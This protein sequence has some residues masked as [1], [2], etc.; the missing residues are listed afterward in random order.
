MNMRFRIFRRDRHDRTY[1]SLTVAFLRR[2]PYVLALRAALVLS[3]ATGLAYLLD[4]LGLSESNVVMVFVLGVLAVT[5]LAGRTLG[6]ISSV[7]GVLAFN[8]LFT[9]PKFTLV[10]ND[11]TYLITFAVMLV[12][13]FTTSGL[14]GRIQQQAEAVAQR[15][16]RTE[17]L[18]QM[19]RSLLRHSGRTEVLKNA[20]QQLRH[21]LSTEVCCYQLDAD[22]VLAA[23]MLTD[24]AG[25]EAR[26]FSKP[27]EIQL[28]E[29][30]ARNRRTTVS[31][32]PNTVNTNVLYVPLVGSAAV[33]GVLGVLFKGADRYLAQ[34]LTGLF[35]TFA[36][37][38][39]LAMD[40]EQLAEEHERTRLDA[41]G[42][43]LKSNLL[44]SISHD[45]RTPLSGISGSANALMGTDHEPGYETRREL[46]HSIYQESTW[47]SRVVENLLSLTR[48]EGRE[49]QPSRKEEVVD[50][51]V[52]STVE[53]CKMRLENRT[54]KTSLPNKVV[55]APMDGN[56][57]EQVLVNLVD[58]AIKHT[59]E[60]TAINLEVDCQDDGL[61]FMVTD[62]GP[63]FDTRLIPHLF[64]R[65]TAGLGEAD[66]RRGVG[67]GLAICKTI[68]DAHGG[69][70]RADNAPS[71]GARMRVTIPMGRT[72]V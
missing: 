11:S 58:N 17:A 39:S 72:D 27:S 22:D 2:S 24:S 46:A 56:L 21:L 25:E 30:V 6:I 70:I 12:V 60:G 34:E 71:G 48:L 9:A 14:T 50:D 8:F 64:D 35:E 13:T 42:E 43:R 36:A 18:Y 40:R 10:V 19:S 45:L 65:F 62:D 44:R 57:M 66:S 15:E 69:S 1:N 51:L 3:T 49:I 5:V 20:L 26:V 23:P 63:G 52:A 68:V 47:L 33:H 53:H 4:Q 59:P 67:L 41:E 28:A 29:W 54:L 16:R 55:T 61:V 38:I 7:I 32:P 31:K 37:Q